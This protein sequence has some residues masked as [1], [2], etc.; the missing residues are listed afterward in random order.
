MKKFLLL[1]AMLVACGSKSDKP[2]DDKG[3]G[4]TGTDPCSVATAKAVDQM[5]GARLKRLDD[6]A[7]SGTAM[8][9]RKARVAEQ[10]NTM[11]AVMA[12]HCN[13]NKWSQDVIDCYGNAT[14]REAIQACRT[15]LPVEQ[16]QSLLKE[17][18]AAMRAGMGMGGGHGGR[19][20]DHGDGSAAGS[21]DATAKPDGS[22]MAPPAGSA[23]PPPPA[24]SAAPAPAG[25]AK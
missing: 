14:T 5:I 23:T 11:K 7:G 2:A 25:S 18:T 16:Q 10:G 4:T 17:E 1:A 22:G 21:G 9:D 12:K 20:F 13:E 3:G 19:R 6:K 8:D 24:G 15:K